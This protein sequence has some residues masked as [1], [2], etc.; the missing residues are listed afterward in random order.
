MKI[1]LQILWPAFLVAGALEA[2]V[3]VVVDP[4]SLRWFGH[5]PVGLSVQGVYSVTFFIFWL[6]IATAGA[7]TRL[8]QD[9]MR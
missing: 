3:F 9:D 1:A 4:A 5:D 8:L 2:L 6:A 7:L